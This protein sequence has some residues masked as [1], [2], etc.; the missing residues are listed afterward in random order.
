MSKYLHVTILWH[1]FILLAT[2]SSFGQAQYRVNSTY[3]DTVRI[4]IMWNLSGRTFDDNVNVGHQTRD[5]I[6]EALNVSGSAIRPENV[7]IV[8]SV[9]ENLDWNQIKSYW[10]GKLPHVIVHSN[11]GYHSL[12]GPNTSDILDSAAINKVGVVSIG[13][14]AAHFATKT[15][16]FTDV[17]NVPRPMGGAESMDSLWVG[18]N[19]GADQNVKINVIGLNGIISNAIEKI[20][21]GESYINFKPFCQDNSNNC[22]NQSDAD[23]YAV[24]N[25]S[26]L[27]FLGYQRAFDNGEHVA[28]VNE[29][30][31]LV[32]FQDTVGEAVRRG[33]A[34]SYQPQFLEN[35]AASQQI[36]Y[37]AI[38]F[39]SLAHT[40]SAKPLTAIRLYPK[41]GTPDVGGNPPLPSLDTVTAGEPFSLYANVFDSTHQWRPEF[42]DLIEWKMVDS[43]GNP[44]LST[45]T[46]GH[47]VFSPTEAYGNVTITASFTDPKKPGSTI[48]TTINLYVQPGKPHHITVQESEEVTNKRNDMHTG[49]ISLPENQNEIKLYAVVRDS[50]GNFIRYATGAEWKS[51]DNQIATAEPG[52][53]KY[54]GTIIKKGNGVTIVT[55][56][57]P[58]IKEATVTIT[59]INTIV[60]NLE[61]AITRDTSGD[62]YLDRI[63]LVFDTTTTINKT[64]IKNLSYNGSG[65]SVDTVICTDGNASGKRFQIVLKQPQNGAFQTGWTP[66]ITIEQN[67]IPLANNFIC[68]DGAG[69]VIGN[70]FHALGTGGTSSVTPDT[71]RVTLSEPVS[72][73]NALSGAQ[74]HNYFNYYN[75][76]TRITTSLSTMEV[77]G[78]T[79]K[80]IMTPGFQVNVYDDSLQLASTQQ[81]KDAEGNIAPTNGR[82]A[83]IEVEESPI[84]IAPGKSPFEPG[85]DIIPEK[86]RKH[87]ENVIKRRD[88]G[89]IQ[90]SINVTG[91]IVGVFSRRPLKIR[92]DGTYGEADVYDAVGNIVSSDLPVNKAIGS[93]YGI[94]WDG[95][96]ENGRFVGSGTYL[97]IVS[98]TELD[99]KGVVKKI[100]VGVRR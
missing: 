44:V 79:I 66:T 19:K 6:E 71:L 38:M 85:K 94:F 23:K 31:V 40:L 32:A 21:D 78:D 8:A 91:T 12:S 55:I 81:V 36:V 48:T 64:D 72:N 27:T 52:S 3:E 33:V 93:D 51:R 69:P 34:L 45:T 26:K 62:G 29:L 10:P 77:D 75:G 96:N 56:S 14:D 39:A 5:F 97:F 11:A 16:G 88:P 95:R 49:T 30:N 18:L 74:P 99:G 83:P 17:E 28:N 63:D 70:V 90:S 73:L 24:L 58:G 37:D 35:K 65:L 68:T 100:K 22:R 76:D 86:A 82:K 15:F 54:D 20:L 4:V 42:S 67:S 87:Y 98:I 92:S 89:K 46:G 47:T 53:Q 1:F 60:A 84:T 80:I 41:P 7:K 50:L 57:E 43:N 13:D 9:D 61:S 2:V 25:S 59:A